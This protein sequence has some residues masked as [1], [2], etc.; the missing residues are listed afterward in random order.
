MSTVT[1]DGRTISKC[2]NCG[3]SDSTPRHHVLD[4][5]NGTAESLHFTCCAKQGC[6][7]C[8]DAVAA[9]DA[10]HDGDLTAY[11]TKDI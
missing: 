5:N 2:D 10:D 6:D 4:P 9:A 1:D 8:A 11:V 7:V 3:K